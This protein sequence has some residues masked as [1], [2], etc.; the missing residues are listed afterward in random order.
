MFYKPFLVFIFGFDRRKGA[1]YK[2]NDRIFL[3]IIIESSS[4]SHNHISI[5][6]ILVSKPPKELNRIIL[7]EWNTTIL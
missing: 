7:L 2:L 1:N 6:T 3:Q 5:G 4:E